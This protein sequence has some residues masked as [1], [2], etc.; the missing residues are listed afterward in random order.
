MS[1][2]LL[3]ET[4]DGVRYL[5]L[6]RPERTNALTDELG[7]AIRS[8]F[9]RSMRF[10]LDEM[11]HVFRGLSSEDGRVAVRAIL[12]ERSPSFQGR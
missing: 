5:R 6:N 9:K 2:V 8:A 3:E 1:A 7:C 12:V 10:P 11:N 4:T